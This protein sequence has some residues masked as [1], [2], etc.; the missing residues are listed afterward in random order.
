MNNRA[1]MLNAFLPATELDDPERFAGRNLQVRELADSLHLRGSTPLIY[2][3]R[4]LGKSSLALQL[5]LIAMGNSELLHQLNAERLALPADAHY[6]TFYVTCTDA[7]KSFQDLLQA[8]VNAAESVE[9]VGSGAASEL[10]DRVTRKRL[11]LKFVE[12]ES[13]KKYAV[14]S[15]RL[16]YQDLNL[17]EKLV[18]LSELLTRTYGQPVL[19]V[20]DELDRMEST[21]GLAS[22]LKAASGG[23]LKFVLVGIASNVSDLLSDHQSLE[24]R[25][26]PVRVPLMST[27]ELAQIVVKAQSYL[28]DEGF[29]IKFSSNA[30]GKLVQVSAGFPWFVH[31]LGQQC[32]IEADR[33]GHSTIQRLHVDKAIQG[34]VDSRLA[35]QFSDMYQA[36]VRDSLAREK[37]LRA[38][39]HWTDPDI[40]TGEVYKILKNN[41]GVGSGSTHRGQLCRPEFGDI[42]FV[43]GIQKRGLVRFRNEMFKAYVRMRPSIYSGVDGVVREAYSVWNDGD[44]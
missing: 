32:V 1:A 8:L 13:T 14:E 23:D 20:I 29:D 7:T 15:Q 31:V 22:F 27:R 21:A 35:Q 24:R 11:T 18:Q 4:G 43:P 9:S 25:L 37:T 41:L 3:D 5:R 10:V 38:F 40:P 17:E 33:N 34:I 44:G 12:V 28:R 2:G 39:A 42:L 6:L 30:I 19:F 26:Q 36:A 16:S